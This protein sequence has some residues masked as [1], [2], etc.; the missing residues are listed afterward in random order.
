LTSLTSG[1]T[2]FNVGAPPEIFKINQSADNFENTHSII[3]ETEKYTSGQ[4]HILLDRKKNRLLVFTLDQTLI[5]VDLKDNTIK[6]LGHTPGMGGGAKFDPNNPNKVFFC[7]TKEEGKV[8]PPTIETGLYEVD[9]SND[10]PRFRL[11]L[12][13]VLKDKPDLEKNGTVYS[14]KDAPQISLSDLDKSNDTRP[15]GVCDDIAISKDGQRIYIA[16]PYDTQDGGFG[17]EFNGK[18]NQEEILMA[19]QNGKLWM[20]DRNSEKLFLLGTGFAFLDGILIEKYDS[21]GRETSLL[22][23]ELSRYRLL[24]LNISDSS[25]ELEKVFENLPG[26]PNALEVDDLGRI[27][28]AFNKMRSFSLDLSINFPIFKRAFQKF[29]LKA[30]QFLKPIPKETGIVTL[31]IQPD[32]TYKPVYYTVHNGSL[33]TSISNVV[34]DFKNDKLYFAIFDRRYPGIHAISIPEKLKI[35]QNNETQ[36]H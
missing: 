21:Y 36:L 35:K 23:T 9:L 29:L 26:M 7:A 12:S 17:D 5:S 1:A 19:K 27:Y 33:I 25:A 34:P 6:M 10:R 20:L 14:I 16:E 2:E 24:R 8:Y 22:F 31:E 11:I 18:T 13:R 32:D 3:P 15:F 30:P 28:M 4:D